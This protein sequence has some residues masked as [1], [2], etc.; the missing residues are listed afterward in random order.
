LKTGRGECWAQVC[1]RIEVQKKYISITEEKKRKRLGTEKLSKHDLACLERDRIGQEAALKLTRQQKRQAEWDYEAWLADRLGS[2]DAPIS[3]QSGAV[4]LRRMALQDS[5]Q[6]VGLSR[7]TFVPPVAD[8]PNAG[9]LNISSE[10]GQDG[11][12]AQSFGPWR[13]EHQLV[14]HDEW[15]QTGYSYCVI[16]ARGSSLPAWL[17]VFVC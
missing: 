14:S 13:R 10:R 11:D 6:N 15:E 8:N 1:A 16:N 7:S 5:K 9:F 3:E 2:A 4:W 17:T 12:T